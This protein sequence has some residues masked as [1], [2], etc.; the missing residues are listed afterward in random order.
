M[1]SALLAPSVSLP[2][3]HASTLTSQESASAAEQE[4]QGLTPFVPSR[5][6]FRWPKRWRDQRKEEDN[7]VPPLVFLLAGQSNMVGNAFPMELDSDTL[8]RIDAVAERVEVVQESVEC[9]NGKLQFDERLTPAPRN[10]S[11]IV[12][13]LSRWGPEVSFGLHMAEVTGRRLVLIKRSQPGTSLA[14]SWNVNFDQ[15]VQ[16]YSSLGLERPH[17]CSAG[18][19][20]SDQ[21]SLYRKLLDDFRATQ[22]LIRKALGSDG[23]LA[24]AVWLQGESDAGSPETALAYGSSLGEFIE[25]LRGDTLTDLPF[26]AVQPAKMNGDSQKSA[27]LYTQVV[28]GTRDAIARHAPA[29]F[30]ENVKD[31]SSADYLPTFRER[32]EFLDQLSDCLVPATCTFNEALEA[33]DGDVSIKV[34][35]DYKH[36]DTEALLRIGRRSALA[37]LELKGGASW[38]TKECGTTTDTCS[39]KLT[40]LTRD[41]GQDIQGLYRPSTLDGTELAHLERLSA[42]KACDVGHGERLSGA[43]W[44]QPNSSK[45][46][47]SCTWLGRWVADEHGG[48]VGAAAPCPIDW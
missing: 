42:R 41:R 32:V 21:T 11:A 12:R 34:E 26:V 15:I 3:G 48:A 43:G 28:D 27:E 24:G 23:T 46:D 2:G 25:A 40:E 39:K 37:M 19:W 1:L 7:G 20:E 22:G 9:D 36:Y 13:H 38:L 33:Y 30:L 6:D 5:F 8:A 18:S 16:N 29:A 10:L 17:L 47:C 45:Q 14:F 35:M 4:A 44:A 31:V